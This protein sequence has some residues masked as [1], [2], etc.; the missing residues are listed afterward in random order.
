M[1]CCPSSPLTAG[2]RGQTPTGGTT[3]I[4]PESRGDGL[5]PQGLGV[6]DHRPGLLHEVVDAALR[7]PILVMSI[8]SA[9][10]NALVFLG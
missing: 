3:S 2:G 9:V 5:G 10:S 1:E 6:E 7:D 8:D 4:R